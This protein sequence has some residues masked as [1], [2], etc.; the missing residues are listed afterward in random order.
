MKDI[1]KSKLHKGKLILKE[2]ALQ[3]YCISDFKEVFGDFEKDKTKPMIIH[4]A[5]EAAR[6]TS[7][8]YHKKMK[9]LGKLAGIPDLIIINNGIIFFIELKAEDGKLNSEQIKVIDCIQTH[10]IQCFLC[11]TRQEFLAAC[12]KMIYSL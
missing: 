11:K 9:I 12:K 4:I 2:D 5:N 6:N 7:F 10:N 8:G 3:E 1:Y